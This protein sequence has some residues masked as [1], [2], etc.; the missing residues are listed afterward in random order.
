[1]AVG[2]IF[3][4]MGALFGNWA[5]LIPIIK[6]KFGLDDAQLGLMI[7]CLPVGGFLA[8]PVSTWFIHKYG[9]QRMTLIGVSIM[10]VCYILPVAAPSPIW[11]GMGLLASGMGIAFTNVSMNTCASVIEVQ[12]KA[13]IMATCHGLFS[14]GLMMGSLL[15]S[16]MIGLGVAPFIQSLSISVTLGI[17]AWSLSGIILSIKDQHDHEINGDEPKQGFTWPRGVLLLM[18][19]VAMCTNLTEGAMADWTA[20]YMRDVVKSAAY[21]LGWGLAAYSGSM[22]LGRFIGDYII[23]R[24]GANAILK[25]G[26]ILSAAGLLMAILIPK[27]WVCVVAFGLVGFGVSCGAP[28]MYG[29]AARLP[30]LAKGV[31]LATLNTFSVVAFLGGP[32]MIGFISK[33]INLQT[34]IGLVCIVG[35]LW[36]WLSGKVKL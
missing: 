22:A 3:L 5:T 23:P 15:S 17:I 35:L 30:N 26:G 36:S 8:N 28:I 24:F 7:L 31:G 34:G 21:T 9:M 27:T 33:A 12:M 11:V 1:M 18:I 32:V 14:T 4:I 25:Y 16:T 13:H 2:V 19:G 29:A 6:A 10:C 20:V